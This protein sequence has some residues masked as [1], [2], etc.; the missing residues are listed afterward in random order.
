MTRRQFVLGVPA[1]ALAACARP[2]R[3]HFHSTPAGHTLAWEN[4]GAVP[5]WYGA[6]EIDQL[7]DGAVE[8]AVAYLAKYGAHPELVRDLARAHRIIGIDLARFAIPASPTGWASGVYYDGSRRIGVAF[9]S[10]ASGDVVP[11]DAPAWTAYQWPTRSVPAWDW[12]VVP[13]AFPALG[14]ELGHAI[15][16][17]LFEHGWTPPVVGGYSVGSVADYR[18]DCVV[19]TED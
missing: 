18:D 10:R 12:G 16:G 4:H 13:R 8:G 11:A 6:A 14:H 2:D 15:Y 5:G 9:W 1:A 7:L 3:Y 19:V 17:P